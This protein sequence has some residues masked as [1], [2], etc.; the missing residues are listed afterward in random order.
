VAGA[1]TPPA[2]P[3]STELVLIELRLEALVEP[4][5]L[6]PQSPDFPTQLLIFPP[7]ALDVRLPWNGKTY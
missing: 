3:A 4:V 1:A 5:A 7:Q 6:V 2:A